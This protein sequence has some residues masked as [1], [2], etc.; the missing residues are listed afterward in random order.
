MNKYVASDLMRYAG[1]VTAGAFARTYIKSKSFR[2]QVA[3]RLVN[4]KGIEKIGGCCGYFGTA[5]SSRLV[6]TP[7]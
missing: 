6:I 1:K 3:F 5:R 4:G 2:W 7:A